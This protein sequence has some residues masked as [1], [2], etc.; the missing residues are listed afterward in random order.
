[1]FERGRRARLVP[2][3]LQRTRV[4]YALRSEELQR[5]ES[6]QTEVLGLVRISSRSPAI[7]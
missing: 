4:M 3:P 1:V 7:R 6:I 5:D 2:E